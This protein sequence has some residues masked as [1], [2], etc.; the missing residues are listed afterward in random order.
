MAF[1]ANFN[2]GQWV[3]A[4]QVARVQ[5]NPHWRRKPLDHPRNI[6]DWVSN[7][8]TRMAAGEVA[9]WLVGSTATWLPRFVP[10]GASGH[11]PLEQSY[12]TNLFDRLGFFRLILLPSP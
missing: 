7:A 8:C 12:C 5:S 10:T 4:K 3:E 11:P 1:W 6:S 2:D 9:Q